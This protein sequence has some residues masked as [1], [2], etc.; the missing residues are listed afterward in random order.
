[1]FAS[2]DNTQVSHVQQLSP[3]AT[4]PLIFRSQYSTR[5]PVKKEIVQQI[6][7]FAVD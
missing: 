3:L 7:P 4:Y 6:L 2:G 1:M 5:L